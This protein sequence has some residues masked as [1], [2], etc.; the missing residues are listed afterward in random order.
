MDYLRP[1]SRLIDQVNYLATKSEH[2]YH[3]R[4]LFLAATSPPLLVFK[5]CPAA[6]VYSLA[7][8]GTPASPPFTV[9][10]SFRQMA[11]EVPMINWPRAM[12]RDFLS[13][14]LELDHSDIECLNNSKLTGRGL[15]VAD[16]NDLREVGFHISTRLAILSLRDETVLRAGNDE[17]RPKRKLGPEKPLGECPAKRLTKQG[18]HTTGDLRGPSIYLRIKRTL[19]LY[20]LCRLSQWIPSI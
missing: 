1:S 17:G 6:Q 7:A 5:L 20:R 16:R 3:L 12:V 10:L 15:L 14:Q 2:I 19:S 8:P 9:A 18:T 4:T 11:S 13:P